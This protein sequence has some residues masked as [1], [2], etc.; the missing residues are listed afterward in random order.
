MSIPGMTSLFSFE[1][2]LKKGMENQ[3]SSGKIMRV[4]GL[5]VRNFFLD[6]KRTSLC[7]R[8]ADAFKN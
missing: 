7:P 2:A 6:L 3:V 8:I 1:R 4:N 5:I